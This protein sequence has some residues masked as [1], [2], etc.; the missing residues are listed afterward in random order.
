VNYPLSPA[1]GAKIALGEGT[2]NSAVTVQKS[3]NTPKY[4]LAGRWTGKNF[5]YAWV[6]PG[7]T[8][9]DQKGLSLP[10]RTDWI[11]AAAPDFEAKLQAKAIQLNRIYGWLTLSVPGAAGKDAFPYRL[12]LRKTGA[13]E[14]LK[15]G[16]DHTTGGETY[17]LWLTADSKTSAVEPR[18][19][20]VLVID[21]DG[22]VDVLFP[23][24]M[25]NSGNHVPS[26]SDAAPTAIELT[27]Q[28]FDLTVGPPYGLDTY[29]LLTSKEELN[30][31]LFPAQGVRS[32]SATRGGNSPL[33]NLLVG[34]GNTRGGNANQPVPITWSVQSLT[35][36]SVEK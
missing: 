15:Q 13:S 27:S 24:T 1:Q 32:E 30:P 28:K 17:K 34:I 21:R 10:V 29:V 3:P 35:I 36:P 22:S 5:E 31:Q 6:R 12:E 4:V 9:A 20:Y 19:V 16:R 23:S 8:E 2:A 26:E 14:A 33:E 7:V 11:S 25:S 18:W